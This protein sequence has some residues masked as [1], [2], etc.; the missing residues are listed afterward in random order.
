MDTWEHR[1][2]R[3]KRPILDS[4]LCV[5]CVCSGWWTLLTRRNLLRGHCACQPR[6]AVGVP[7]AGEWRTRVCVACQGTW[8]PLSSPH[9]CLL[10]STQCAGGSCA[11]QFSA[12][13]HSVLLF[14]ACLVLEGIV[15]SS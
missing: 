1:Q 2:A 13:M 7:Q 3:T 8:R 10:F 9:W 6:A 15:V 12:W 14:L 5:L 4:K 11:C